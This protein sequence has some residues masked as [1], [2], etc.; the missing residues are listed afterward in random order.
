VFP[1]G[2]VSAASYASG[3]VSPGELIS[4]FGSNLGPAPPR[5]IEFDSSGNVLTQLGPSR[6]LF[7]GD[8]A[9]I[10]FAADNQINL[11]VPQAIAGRTSTSVEVEVAGTRSTPSVVPVAAIR[12]GLF[13]LNAAGQAAVLNQDGSVN[14]PG[15]PATRGTMIQVFATGCGETTP[16]L[17]SGGVAPSAG[18][19]HLVN[20]AVEVTIGGVN[21]PV[22]FAGAS[23]QS[24]FG[25]VQINVNVP[26]G[27]APGPAVPL[28]VTVGGVAAQ[29]G[30]NLAIV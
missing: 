25:L 23:P 30:V 22:E 28:T 7:D 20:A 19:N 29:S 10:I 1:G 8:P 3:S 4:I 13:M 21:A 26:M 5:G 17:I 11:V 18:P 9:P 15:N 2:I 16:P 12:P 6:V 24:I 27:A 14:G